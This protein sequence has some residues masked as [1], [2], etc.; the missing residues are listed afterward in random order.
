MG[1]PAGIGPEIVL[2]ALSHDDVY[3]RCR[4]LVIGDRRILERAAPWTGQA[5]V[6]IDTVDQPTQGHFKPGT[7]ALF[8]VHNAPP[9]QCVPGEISAVAGHAAVEY[10]FRACDLALAG[11]VDAMVT[12]PLN[13][14]AMN[15]AGFRFRRAY[16]V[17]G[18]ANKHAQC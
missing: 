16:G 5:E 12:A 15:R 6:A 18:R 17:A 11:E 10:V 13:K 3:D 7:I 9:D 1:D 2:K 8:D 4:P 14:A